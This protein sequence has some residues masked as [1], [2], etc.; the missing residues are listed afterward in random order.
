MRVLA[1]VG[2]VPLLGVLIDI[3]ALVSLLHARLRV[4]PRLRGCCF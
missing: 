3:G 2:G 1:V 4:S